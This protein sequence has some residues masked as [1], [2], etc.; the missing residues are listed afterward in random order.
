MEKG[1]INPE[2]MDFCDVID[3]DGLPKTNFKS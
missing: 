3:S 2:I 1:A